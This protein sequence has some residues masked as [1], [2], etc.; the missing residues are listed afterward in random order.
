MKDEYD[1]IIKISNDD[2]KAFEELFNHYFQYLHN[3]A[4]NRLG[5]AELAD[6][7]IQDI[8][9]DLWKNRRRLNIHTSIKSYLYQAVRNK[10]Y[11]FIRHQTIR[12]KEVYIRKIYDEYYSGN[13][14]AQSHDLLEGEELKELITKHL[15]E[16]PDK[17]RNIFLLSREKHFTHQEIAEKLNCSPKTVE[18]HISKVLRHLRSNLK[19]YVITL[20]P[21]SLL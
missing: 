2:G 13:P 7:I 12:Q 1:L 18:Y 9:T 4:Y 15:N 5:S 19:E 20:I 6:D 16:L 21:F 11:K 10:V 3:I 17:S 8:F 14:F